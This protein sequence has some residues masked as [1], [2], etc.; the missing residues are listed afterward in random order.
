MFFLFYCFNSLIL[1]I[2]VDTADYDIGD[3][4][5][6]VSYESNFEDLLKEQSKKGN[7]YFKKKIPEDSLAAHFMVGTCDFLKTEIV[8]LVELVRPTTFENFV[9]VNIPT[10]YI[11][12]ALGPK[13][14][15]YKM[16]Q[17]G[18]CCATLFSDEVS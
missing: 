16:E 10:K 9:E 3:D 13:N 15:A 1:N 8:A 14:K 2:K 6:V 17:I 11:F 12:I 18:R 4:G 7:L 5:S